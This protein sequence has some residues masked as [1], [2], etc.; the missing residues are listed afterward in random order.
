MVE[1]KNLPANAGDIRDVA[2]VPG[3]GRSHGGGHDNL[4]RYPCLE[5]PVDRGAWPATAH[6]VGHDWS[7]IVCNVYMS[8]PISQFLPLPYPW[9]PY[10]CSLCLCLYFCFVNKT[11]YS[12]FFFRFQIY[13]LIYNTCFSLSDLFHFVWQSLGPSM[14]LQMT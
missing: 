5:N 10:I 2:S 7:D 14:S 13:A 4:L 1:V 6:W 3:S 9:Y 12:I 11:V 8:I